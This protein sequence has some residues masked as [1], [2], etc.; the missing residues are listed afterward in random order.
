MNWLYI[1]SGVAVIFLIIGYICGNKVGHKQ[2]LDSKEINSARLSSEIQQKEQ[3]IQQLNDSIEKYQ[4]LERSAENNLSLETQRLLK[5]REDQLSGLVRALD[6]REK[7]LDSREKELEHAKTELCDML[8][9]VYKEL[10]A[11]HET[12]AADNK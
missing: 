10:H 3:S 12:G 4:K 5:D 8:R 6:S 2:E 9:S 7:K 1:T 11:D